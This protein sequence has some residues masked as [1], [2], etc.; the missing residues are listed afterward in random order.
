MTRIPNRLTHA[1]LSAT[2]WGF[3]ARRLAVGRTSGSVRP[4]ASE[5]G[6]P[7]ALGAGAWPHAVYDRDVIADPGA[8]RILCFGDSNTHGICRRGPTVVGTATPDPDY[9]RLDVDR[10]WPGVLQRLLGVG[11]EVI[12]EGLNGRTTDLQEPGRPGLAG[13]SYFVPC[14]LSHRPLDVVIVMLGGNDLKP[15]FGR[16]PREVADALAGYIDDV[17]AHATNGLGE[18]PVVVL[19]GGTPVDDSAP[20]YRDLVGDHLDP[21]HAA[22]ARE[23]DDEVRRVA[24]HRRVLYAAAAEVTCPGE[25]GIHLDIASHSR[26]AELLA[27]MIQTKAGRASSI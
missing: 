19:V 15:G 27:E 13:R 12:E 24:D 11:Y 23:L 5:C 1:R 4:A 17:T 7:V 26:L 20:A 14:L 2:C 10:R 16:S 8:V 9:V 18:V 21:R 6:S 22:R 3:E 25:D